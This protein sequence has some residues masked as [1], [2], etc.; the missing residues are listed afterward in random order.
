[1]LKYQD[2]NMELEIEF[3]IHF[4]CGITIY[5]VLNIHEKIH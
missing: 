1:M 2:E 5:N 4:F 3:E